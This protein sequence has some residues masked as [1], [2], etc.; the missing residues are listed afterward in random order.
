MK[1]RNGFLSWLQL[2]FGI[3]MN[4][5]AEAYTY[6]E[7]VNC[8]MSQLPVQLMAL[9]YAAPPP[10]YFKNWTNQSINTIFY[11]FKVILDFCN[12]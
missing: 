1:L 11:N 6:F 10:L 5:L 4:Q 2:L 12:F 9:C 8:Q 3:D 7:L